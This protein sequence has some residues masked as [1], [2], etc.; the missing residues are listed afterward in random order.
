MKMKKLFLLS[1]LI[2][3][4]FIIGCKKNSQEPFYQTPD[5]D[6]QKY[7]EE[8]P[9]GSL[10]TSTVSF[11]DVTEQTEIISQ[12]ELQKIGKKIQKTAEIDFTAEKYDDF[13]KYLRESI[14]KYDAFIE[15]EE[16]TSYDNYRQTNFV[17][18]VKNSQFDSLITDIF[19]GEGKV[20]YKSIK[21]N[22]VTANYIDTYQHTKTLLLQKKRFE[23][24][25]KNAYTVNDILNVTSYLNQIDAQI[26]ASKAR[27]KYL[28]NITQYSTIN[29]VVS[30]KASI[31]KD[32]FFKSIIKALVAGWHGLLSFIL[33]LF[34]IWPVWILL[35]IAIFVVKKIRKNK[36]NNIKNG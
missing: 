19:N 2:L 9:T 28:D 11:N 35:I 7:S 31:R 20:T 15:N 34:Y 21:I 27:L 33:I 29:L 8:E 17:I 12:E 14:K 13:I 16:E 1:G 10:D 30:E 22:D 18:R 6:L 36:S 26:D 3:F 23:E 32:S 25:M 24:I 4:I 5:V